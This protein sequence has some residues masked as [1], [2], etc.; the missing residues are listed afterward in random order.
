MSEKSRSNR[1]KDDEIPQTQ[2]AKMPRNICYAMCGAQFAKSFRT[3]TIGIKENVHHLAGGEWLV[4]DEGV[5]ELGAG[6]RGLDLEGDELH[7]LLYAGLQLQQSHQHRH[8]AKVYSSP[9]VEFNFA[10]SKNPSPPSLTEPMFLAFRN[11]K[12]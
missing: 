10:K 8:H 9:L 6:Q 3:N 5:L 11:W 2:S 12:I 4:P 7:A 1:S